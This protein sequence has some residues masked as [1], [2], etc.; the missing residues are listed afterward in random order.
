M[1]NGT[2][3][4][5]CMQ[6]VQGC[7]T[8]HILVCCSHQLLLGVRVACLA[9]DSHLSQLVVSRAVGKLTEMLATG[10]IKDQDSVDEDKLVDLT[11]QLLREHTVRNSYTAKTTLLK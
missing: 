5:I 4:L 6:Y 3:K 11:C 9:T 2:C 7:V 8:F 10:R 1:N